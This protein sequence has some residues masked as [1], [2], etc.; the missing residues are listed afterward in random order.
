MPNFRKFLE[1]YKA[2]EA[3]KEDHGKGRY[4]SVG[5]KDADS[6]INNVEDEYY[7]LSMY[8]SPIDKS[9][10]W[11]KTKRRRMWKKLSAEYA[12]LIKNNKKCL[13]LEDS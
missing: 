10:V 7:V 3:F 4:I 6:F 5:E 1:H 2:S 8:E 11:D 9:I 12:T 13:T